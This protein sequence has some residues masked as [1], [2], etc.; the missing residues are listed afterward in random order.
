MLNAEQCGQYAR[1]FLTRSRQMTDPETKA[2]M[3]EIAMY[4]TQLAAKS[5]RSPS[6]DQE[7]YGHGA[8]SS[9][10]LPKQELSQEA[11]L[12]SFVNNQ[13]IHSPPQLETKSK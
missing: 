4:W 3:I 13:S 5:D 1:K 9:S 10:P 8:N 6:A 2:A 11:Q 12:N 7:Q